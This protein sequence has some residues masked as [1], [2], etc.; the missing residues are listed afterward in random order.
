MTIKGVGEDHWLARDTGCYWFLWPVDGLALVGSAAELGA[1][2]YA[3]QGIRRVVT[4]APMTPDRRERLR[5]W[6]KK[7]KAQMIAERNH[8]LYE[9]SKREE[10]VEVS[11][12]T[13]RPLF[14]PEDRPSLP[15]QLWWVRNLNEEDMSR[16][17]MWGID[18]QVVDK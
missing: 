8:D 7:Q 12:Q 10:Q 1:R 11:Y 17:K 2:P 9:M 18:P 15:V 4:E 3:N 5:A 13:A 6:I 14:A 16:L